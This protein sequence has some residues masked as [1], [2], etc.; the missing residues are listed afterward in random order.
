MRV[1]L[2]IFVAVLLAACNSNYHNPATKLESYYKNGAPMAVVH[3]DSNKKYIGSYYY[4]DGTPKCISTGKIYDIS[5]TGYR[6]SHET[7]TEFYP[8]GS[9][10]PQRI[11]KDK[12][13]AY[14]S[15]GTFPFTDNGKKF[16][17]DFCGERI[18]NEYILSI[19]IYPDNK[20]GEIVDRYILRCKYENSQ[21]IVKLDSLFGLYKF[22]YNITEDGNIDVRLYTLQSNKK[23][24]EF[25]HFDQLKTLMNK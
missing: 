19:Y 4:P 5:N 17:I 14:D 9:L 1:I 10:V 25:G 3:Y 15:L 2:V 12:D 24:F 20:N 23:V 22:E 6:L 16:F 18:A 8:D 11:M 13:F 21:W 7:S